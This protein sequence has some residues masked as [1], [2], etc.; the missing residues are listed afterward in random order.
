MPRLNTT[1]G[2]LGSLLALAVTAWW[3]ASVALQEGLAFAGV[4]L[5]SARATFWLILGQWLLLGLFAARWFCGTERE[6]ASIGGCAATALAVIAPAWPLLVL[7]WLTSS[8]SAFALL[9][10][11]LLAIGF[12]SAIVLLGGMLGRSSVDM[13]I[14]DALGSATGVTMAAIIWSSRAGLQAWLQP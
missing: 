7:L 11:Q 1:P 5:L 9:V 13:T 4:P 2:V 12:G 10:I 3:L 6:S 14:S 8:L